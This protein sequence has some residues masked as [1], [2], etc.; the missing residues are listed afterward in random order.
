WPAARRNLAVRMAFLGA[1][2]PVSVFLAF[3]FISYFVPPS[4][5]FHRLLALDVHTAGGIAG[6][7]VTLITFL[8]FTLVRQRFCTTICPY[9]Y[10]QGILGDDNTLLVHYRDESHL[11]VECKKCVRVCHMGIDIRKSPFQIECVHCGECIDACVDVLHRIGKQGLIHYT[12]G[13]RG[14][15]LG[16][17]DAW[18][19]R[20][21]IRDAKRVIVLLLLA[22]YGC[23]L[24]VALSMRHAVLVQI[25][26][27]RAS[28]YRLDGARVYNRFRFRIANRGKARSAVVFS[29]AQLSGATLVMP[30]NP[31]PADAGTANQGTFE[32]SRPLDAA[33]D[34]VEHFSIIATPVGGGAADTFAETFLSPPPRNSP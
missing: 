13:E 7:A 20:I 1:L 18:Y 2:A 16:D 3:A 19:R 22:C 26:P 25:S 10:L 28:L 31:V 32:I 34:E 24:F 17:R 30:H 12:W 8:D 23:A 27:E 21:G 4:D 5:L 33:K 29:I 15:T 6:A 11:C 14:E 9:G